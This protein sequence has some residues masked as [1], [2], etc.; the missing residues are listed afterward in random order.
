MR[1]VRPRVSPSR[2]STRRGK[3]GKPTVTPTVRRYAATLR[4]DGDV[5]DARGLGEGGGVDGSPARA[6]DCGVDDREHGRVGNV[7]C[8]S[9][10]RDAVDLPGEVPG[11]PDEVVDVE[12]HARVGRGGRAA[13]VAGAHEHE[14]VHVAF[15]RA[16]DL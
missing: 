1:A 11:R 8:V 3:C 9:A 16:D 13:A 7:D 4:S 2:R 6:A 12:V 15:V 10:G 5:V 14:L